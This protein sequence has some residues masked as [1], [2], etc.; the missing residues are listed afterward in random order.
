MAYQMISM[1]LKNVKAL[2]YVAAF[3]PDVG[4]SAAELAGRFPGSTL[5]SALAAPVPL[6][7]GGKTFTSTIL[8]ACLDA[9][10]D[11]MTRVTHA[12]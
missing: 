9:H 1:G 4:E 7:D 10:R 5:G 2:V 3:A 12:E 6:A 8:L 11:E